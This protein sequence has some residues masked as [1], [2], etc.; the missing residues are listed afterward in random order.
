MLDL[1]AIPG[2]ILFKEVGLH[3]ADEAGIEAVFQRQAA[4]QPEIVCRLLEVFIFIAHAGNSMRHRYAGHGSLRESETTVPAF[5]YRIRISPDVIWQEVLLGETVLM[6]VKT[7]VYFGLD[8]L[9]SAIW[10]AIRLHPDAD[11]AFSRLAL[12]VHT[13]EQD[14]ARKF[15]MIIKGLEGS[16]LVQLEY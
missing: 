2:G 1:G 14:L 16:G 11:E 8:E 5:S 6:N 12:S 4:V 7:L 13:P 9:G 10:K 3:G 15:T